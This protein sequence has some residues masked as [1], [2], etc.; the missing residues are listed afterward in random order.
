[1]IG[2]DRLMV[3]AIS[4]PDRQPQDKLQS[5]TRKMKEIERPWD[6]RNLQ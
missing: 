1:M 6:V 5:I 3:H 4:V 2:Y